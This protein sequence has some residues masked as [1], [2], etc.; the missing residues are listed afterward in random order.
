MNKK[1][2]VKAKFKIVG[3]SGLVELFANFGHKL[4]DQ[5]FKAYETTPDAWARMHFQLVL[6]CDYKLI[7]GAHLIS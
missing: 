3:A 5:V 7:C 1:L 6:A 4:E 2:M